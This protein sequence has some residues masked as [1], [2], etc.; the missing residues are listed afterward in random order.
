MGG[1]EERERY[2]A[3]TVTQQLLADLAPSSEFSG[4]L[5]GFDDY[6]SEFLPSCLPVREGV[7]IP[8]QQIWFSRM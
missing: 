8:A 3:P 4:M 2:R 7:L 1:H 5:V 6:V